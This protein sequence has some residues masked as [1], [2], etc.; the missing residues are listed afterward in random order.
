MDI[1]SIKE[2]FI[3]RFYTKYGC[4]LGKDWTIVDIGAAIGEFSLYAAV[5]TPARASLPMSPSPN[6][7]SP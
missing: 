2:T 7:S 5:K 6:R 4:E 1:W 3:D